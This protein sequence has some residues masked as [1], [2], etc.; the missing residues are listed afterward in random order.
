MSK[1]I[2]NFI[3]LLVG[4]G[5]LWYLNHIYP[6]DNVQRLLTSA[7]VLVLLYALF[8]VFLNG[9]VGKR[10][11]DYK[12]RYSFKKIINILFFVV[13]LAVGIR[14]WIE[15][16]QTLLVSYG[17]IAAGVTISLQDFFKNFIGGL[18]IIINS[19]YK[20]GDRIELDG[21][22]GDVIDTGILY[23]TILEIKEWVSGD[24]PTGRIVKIPN[25]T[26][27]T[28]NVNNYTEDH[29]FIWDE[30]FIPIT[31][32]SDW[33]VA[34]R[35]ILKIVKT[36]TNQTVLMA[37]KDFKKL[38]RKYFVEKKTIEPEA[39]VTMTDN[40]IEIHV[41]YITEVRERRSVH[42]ILSQKLLAI[43]LKSDKV[44][45]ASATLGIVN[46]P[47]IEMKSKK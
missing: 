22:Y 1:K 42:N 30:I 17:L 44:K 40:W 32:D 21:K 45:I 34:T 36:E 7:L 41:R 13:I 25:G 46:M 19:L 29:G 37:E 31:Y 47:P 24:Q 6:N 39:F 16:P 15:D 2:V 38:R 5:L 8:I 26:V 9:I 35:N 33:Q 12:L 28:K 20:V 3:I 18:L 4:S 10:I 43:L 23:T 14:I 27:L 11:K